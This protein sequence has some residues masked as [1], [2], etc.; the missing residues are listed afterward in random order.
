MARAVGKVYLVG[1]GPGDVGML[2]LKAQRLLSEAE[3]VLY[4]HLVNPDILKL[5]PQAKLV[6]VGK[7]GHGDATRQ[8]AIESALLRAAR[9]HSRIVRLKGGD[10]FVFGRGGEEA[11]FLAASKI[12][13]A[14]V[15][16][17]TSAV[18]VPAYAGIPVTHRRYASSLAFYTGHEGASPGE[19]ASTWRALA[20]IDTVVLLMGVKN[21]GDN[22]RRL[23]VAGKPPHTPAAIVEWGSYPRQRVLRGTLADLARRATAA[24]F[25]APSIVVVGKVADLNRNLAW[26]G[27][28]PLSGCR[29]LVT[30]SAAQAGELTQVLAERGAEVIAFPT[31]RIVPPA[32]WTRVDAVSK[33]LAGYDWILFTS[34]NAVTAFFERYF[35]RGG[36]LRSLSQVRVAAVGPATAERLRN[37]GLQADRIPKEYSGRGLAKDFAEAEVR[38]KSFL[39]PS[40]D[41]ARDDAAEILRKHGA[42]VTKLVVYRTAMPSYRR[43]ELK[44]FFAGEAFDL[45]T[46]TSPSAIENIFKILRGTPYLKS[47]RQT[48]VAVLGPTTAAA[49]RKFGLKVRVQPKASTL[50]AFIAAVM[51]YLGHVKR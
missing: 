4:D 17:I 30:R 32:S 48:P 44:R 35:A 43:P 21:L 38:G 5:C 27:R 34:A 39:L 49:A 45:L 51:K 2:T 14:V 23:V 25:R 36:D 18:A 28:S 9:S 6:Y 13:F 46:F 33:K 10:P 29:I 15:P 19:A 7:V 26:F 50:E 11:E 24:G 41:L 42:R 3:I 22:L 40:S 12:P 16:G 1:A 47:L 31:I 37:F 8:R 20:G